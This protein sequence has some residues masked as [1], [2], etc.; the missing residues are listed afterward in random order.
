MHWLLLSTSVTGPFSK[1]KYTILPVAVVQN[2]PHSWTVEV[3][4]ECYWCR[5][6]DEYEMTS[7]VGSTADFSS[8]WKVRSTQENRGARK[9]MF[10]NLQPVIRNR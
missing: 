6:I 7:V 1:Q 5:D 10:S 4:K 8:M 3:E 9:S 2:E